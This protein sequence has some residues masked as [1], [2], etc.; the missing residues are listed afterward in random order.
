MPVGTA[1]KP[2]ARARSITVSGTAVVAMS[3]SSGGLAE[4]GVAHGAADHA[5]LLAGVVE[6]GEHL[7][8]RA[9][10]SSQAEFSRRRFTSLRPRHELPIFEMRRHVGRAR[11][12]AGE[13]GDQHEADRGERDRGE[14]ERGQ[15]LRPPLLGM[16]DALARR[17][18]EQ[19]VER[20][21]ARGRA[22][23]RWRTGG[24]RDDLHPAERRGTGRGSRKGTYQ[25]I[26]RRT[27]AHIDCA[28]CPP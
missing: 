13:L 8:Q 3:I 12:R 27:L 17:P 18:Q 22:R 21:T 9:G 14:R 23:P 16:Q 25:Y 11:R 10:R 26:R 7:R 1:L 15:H 2:A 4:H 5:R 20:R 28:G 24:S 6:H 19:R